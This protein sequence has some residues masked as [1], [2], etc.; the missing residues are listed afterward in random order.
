LSGKIDRVDIYENEGK[1]YFR[2][3]DYKSSKHTF[4]ID[5]I[6]SGLDIQLILYLYALHG[7][8]PEGTP[9]GAQYLFASKEKGVIEI[10]RSGLL[11]KDDAIS[12]AVDGED[13]K[14]YTKGLTQ[15]T[16]EEMQQLQDQMRETVLSVAARIL[17]GEARKTPS[18]E[19]CGFCPVRDDCNRAYR[20]RKE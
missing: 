10:Q 7:A 18:K 3:I 6:R 8:I 11:L 14:I 16:I 5:D 2:V 1:I 17:S 12:A 20:Q 4:S 15:R 13:Q 19:A 9:A